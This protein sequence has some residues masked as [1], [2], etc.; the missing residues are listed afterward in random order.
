MS[1]EAA[2]PAGPDLRFQADGLIPAIIQHA[3]SGAVLMLGYMNAESLEKTRQSGLVTFWSRSR[4]QLWTK[5]ETSG[6]TLRVIEIRL[7]CDS[8]ALLVLAEPSGPTCHTGSPSCFSNRLD[9]SAIEVLAP[10]STILTELVDLIKARREAD[11][12]GSYTVKLLKGGVDR[13]G[14]KIGEEAAE[15][16]IAAKNR[17]ASELTYEMADLLY[18]SLLLLEEQNLSLDE[19]YGELRRRMLK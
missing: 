17:S 1:A 3:R 8:D 5:G 4:K 18:H 19:V 13:I 14:K 12:D 15:V 7:D 6:N 10:S 16:I 11:T 9:G 2:S